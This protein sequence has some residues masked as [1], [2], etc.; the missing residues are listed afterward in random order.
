MPSQSQSE[1]RLAVDWD[2]TPMMSSGLTQRS[3]SL[4]I[5]EELL[6]VFVTVVPPYGHTEA[7]LDMF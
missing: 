5:N 1:A 7:P 3:H 2:H 4:S 6:L